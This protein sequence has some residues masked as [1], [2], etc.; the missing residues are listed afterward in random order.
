MLSTVRICPRCGKSFDDGLTRCPVDHTDLEARPGRDHASKL[1][2]PETFVAYPPPQPQALQE[3]LAPR[4]L[5][6]PPPAEERDEAH[7]LAPYVSGIMEAGTILGKYQLVNPIGKGGMGE[8]Y[9]ALHRTLG[10]K[11]ALK[12]LRSKFVENRDAVQRFFLEAQVASKID[13][14]NIVA[15]TDFSEADAGN[16]FYVMEYLEG[17]DLGERVNRAGTLPLADCLSIVQQVA[18]ALEALHGAGIIHRDL[19][20]GNIFLKRGKETPETVKVLDFGL[21]KLSAR[22]GAESLGDS[23]PDALIGTPQYMSPEQAVGA[24]IDH[25]CDIYALGTI[26]YEMVTGVRPLD[27]ST[28]AEQLVKLARDVPV[29]P[30]QRQGSRV[31]LSEGLEALIMRCLEKDPA[32]RPQSAR[33][34]LDELERLYPRDRPV[35]RPRWPWFL[36]AAGL[37]GLVSLGVAL[38]LVPS[39]TRVVLEGGKPA[40]QGRSIARLKEMWGGVAHRPRESRAWQAAERRMDL[41]HLDALR[42]AAGANARVTFERGGALEV[43]ERTE[44]RIEAPLPTAPGE[45]PPQVARLKTGTVRAVARR[46]VP[47]RFI[48][49]DGTTTQIFTRH[50]GPVSIRARIREDGELEVAALD[51]PVTVTAG[52]KTVPLESKQ[53]LDLRGGKPLAPIALP[54]FPQLLSPAV[55]A[56]ISS[57]PVALR[58]R[59][60]AGARRYRVQVSTSTFFDTMLIDEVTANTELLAPSIGPGR[61]IWRART[62]GAGGHD[63]EFGYSRR[64]EL[65]ALAPATAVEGLLE[66]ADRA[67]IKLRDRAVAVPLRWAAEGAAALVVVAKDPQLK[68]YVVTRRRVTGGATA[69]DLDRPGVYYWGAYTIGEGGALTPLFERARRIIVVKRTPPSLRLKKI[70]FGR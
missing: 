39:P 5:Q 42:T 35:Q 19:K 2:Q 7:A 41:Q 24:D 6:Q 34:F 20:P 48:T 1:A 11:V 52:G 67:V 64:F 46:G 56:K 36:L 4:P 29:R 63:G 38:L 13:H 15:I 62:T 60:V 53:L 61:Y 12:L 31:E 17:E 18:G 30:S 70:E 66:P 49:P 43:D 3:T 25:R 37:A 21:I 27:A 8:V 10:R 9:L 23:N 58:W 16:C 54:P 14:P 57:A 69:V 32:R 44:V 45:P 47:L 55:D 26:L 22:V 33:A 50:K 51:G 40:R 68:R 59:P 65:L 28:I